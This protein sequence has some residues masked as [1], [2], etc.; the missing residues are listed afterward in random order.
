MYKAQS[1][2]EIRSRRF[3]PLASGAAFSGGRLITIVEMSRDEHFPIPFV[4]GSKL[5]WP[6]RHR[7]LSNVY[8]NFF[9]SVY[10]YFLLVLSSMG[11][12]YICFL[13]FLK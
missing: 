5:L 2:Q 10:R 13:L 3:S 11:K 6:S 1:M 12:K 8:P 4:I 7:V 9:C